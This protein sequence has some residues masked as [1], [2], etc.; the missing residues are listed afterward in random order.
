MGPWGMILSKKHQQPIAM[1]HPNDYWGEIY[2]KVFPL[3]FIFTP[4]VYESKQKFIYIEM[5]W[6]DRT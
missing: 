5:L 3:E 6:G 4:R 1:N 2:T